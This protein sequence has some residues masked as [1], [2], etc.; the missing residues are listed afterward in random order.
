IR[1]P[2]Y[3]RHRHW[4]DARIAHSNQSANHHAPRRPWSG[5]GPR[6]DGCDHGIRYTVADHLREFRFDLHHWFF[7]LRP[8][9]ADRGGRRFRATDSDRCRPRRRNQPKIVEDRPP[10]GS[11]RDQEAG[12]D[13]EY[14]NEQRLAEQMQLLLRRVVT[15]CDIDR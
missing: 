14:W 2:H 7:G 6:H 11:R 1:L 5:A 3:S 10:Y 9:T 15:D 13:E 12:Y 8:C 4:L